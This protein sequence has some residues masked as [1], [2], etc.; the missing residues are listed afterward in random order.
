MLGC[1]SIF[2]KY[3]FLDLNFCTNIGFTQLAVHFQIFSEDINYV[4]CRCNA[5]Y[6]CIP[7]CLRW[8]L[9]PQYSTYYISNWKV[10]KFKTRSFFI[11]IY[12]LKCILNIRAQTT[13]IKY[14]AVLLFCN[15]LHYWPILLLQNFIWVKIYLHYQY[16]PQSLPFKMDLIPAQSNPS[17]T[18]CLEEPAKYCLSP[19]T[20]LWLFWSWHFTFPSVAR[21]YS[22]WR[23]KDN[24]ETK[25]DFGLH[26]LYRS[27][28]LY[29]LGQVGT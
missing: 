6:L 24:L 5:V 27:P 16:F 7:L 21:Y 28:S 11:Y 19:A 2:P 13:S 10:M 15:W 17:Q 25:R 8:M 9:K 20:D 29:S 1:L 26:H 12:F 4:I 22:D 14:R 3:F 23:G 18:A